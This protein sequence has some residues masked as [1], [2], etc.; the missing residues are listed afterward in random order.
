MRKESDFSEPG[1]L[2]SV[3]SGIDCTPDPWRRDREVR[4]RAQ[5]IQAS[6]RGQSR[7]QKESGTLRAHG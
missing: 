6:H 5:L 1:A 4:E 2:I 3:K 7:E